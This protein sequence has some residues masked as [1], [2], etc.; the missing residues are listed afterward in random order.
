MWIVFK[1]R[2]LTE[3][4]VIFGRSALNIIRKKVEQGLEEKG[5]V[6][7]NRGDFKVS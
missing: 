1:E 6:S 3:G 4:R 2:I 5:G 7:D